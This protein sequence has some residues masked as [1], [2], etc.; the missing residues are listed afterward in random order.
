MY[1]RWWSSDHLSHSTYR[2]STGLVWNPPDARRSPK[3]STGSSIRNAV[4]AFGCQTWRQP[5]WDLS[6]CSDLVLKWARSKSK[7]RGEVTPQ[8]TVDEKALLTSLV[9]QR[10]SRLECEK[11]DMAS[12][13]A[14]ATCWEEVAKDFNSVFGITKRDA[15]QPKKCWNN[16]MKQQW[17]GRIPVLLS[18]SSSRPVSDTF[19]TS[20]NLMRYR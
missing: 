8:G 20:L 14:T 15:A 11:I 18:G 7:K 5:N 19:A 1:V 3:C 2:L 10:R 17:K 4:L 16:L 12:V 13:A 6:P 9:I